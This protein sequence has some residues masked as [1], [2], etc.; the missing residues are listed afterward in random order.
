M[1]ARAPREPI[2]G[3]WL[4]G[5]GALLFLAV[6]VAVARMPAGPA[7]AARSDAAVYRLIAEHRAAEAASLARAA[8]AQARRAHGPGSMQAADA[9]DALVDVA[10]ATGNRRDVPEALT[11]AKESIR[12]REI[13]CGMECPEL[14]KSLL[15]YEA[16]LWRL[17]DYRA[18]LPL[19]ERA[20][21]IR[22]RAFG[23]RSSMV[24]RS[25]YLL[26]EADRAIGDYAAAEKLHRKA[27]SIWETD[28]GPYALDIA[29]SLH[30]LGVLR[31]T[32]GD[33]AGARA[34]IGKALAIREGAAGPE[35]EMVAT[36]INTLGSL[37]VVM[38]D[39]ETAMSLFDRG[40]AI[41]E[42]TLGKND[43]NVARSLANRGRL[44]SAAGDYAAAKTLF[45][46][47]LNIRVS[48]FGP[49]HYLVGRSL[50]DLG[51][52]AVA[53]GRYADA[54]RLFRRA[55]DIQ[56]RDPQARG[57]ELA[58]TLIDDANLALLTGDRARAVRLALEGEAIARDHFL[59]TSRGL[60]EQDALRYETVRSTG[61]DVALSAL[62]PGRSGGAPDPSGPA[63]RVWD[64]IIRSRGMVLDEMAARHRAEPAG[65]TDHPGLAQVA[66]HLP[67]KT[68]L[69]GFVRYGSHGESRGGSTSSYLALVLA[70]GGAA[71]VVVPIGSAKEVEAA[72][73][74][75]QKE[76]GTDPRLDP[77]HEG[78]R[79]YLQTARRLRKVIW[80]PVA[81]K[82]KGL[83]R[84][85]VVPDGA[86]NAVSFAALPG[87]DG[88]YLIESDPSIHYLSAERDITIP[89]RPAGSGFGLLALGG[90]EFDAR[91]APSGGVEATFRSAPPACRRFDA[92]KFGPLP[93][94]R[95]EVDDIESLW[96]AR[97]GALKLTGP[98][99]SEGALKSSAPGR[100]ILHLATHAYFLQNLCPSSLGG[101]L[102]PE[103]G[104]TVG[105][106]P[107]LLSGLALAGANRRSE[108]SGGEE[109]G[110]LTAEEIGALDLSGVEWA[111]L[112]GCETGLGQVLAGEGVVG[113]HRAFKV[114]GVGTLIMSLWPVDDGAA[115]IWMHYLHD[116]RLH[117]LSTVD[118]VR[119]A[120]L[121]MIASQRSS[122]GSTHSYF[123][124]AFVATGDWK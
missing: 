115:R 89:R 1:S 32:M 88:R 80:D 121:R 116:G 29:N 52:L 112:S 107:L 119:R 105:E 100:R 6:G 86:I 109:D 20:L 58:S 103:E 63:A 40:Q 25:L 38:G 94:S 73:R 77:R 101:D 82:L 84:V 97:G 34:L 70:P 10:A 30:Y 68:A 124:G 90:A 4:V 118:A 95:R 71:T 62:P 36:E 37:A 81:P 5:G 106:N 117:G 78:E 72:I 60:S 87:D 59:R 14:A 44:L 28:P 110:I 47:A 54:E 16:L 7:R 64:E 35:S 53:A 56:Q 85:F 79:R 104:A 96:K 12:I 111:V 93:G 113:L 122:G 50:A 102:P 42:R 43:P 21:A 61:L 76:A 27:V 2:V 9:M 65:T 75:W 57:P 123:W 99:A 108:V 45:Q 66:R 92:L 23:P 19:A 91:P 24:A 11:L 69:V 18:A 39:R 13:S 17:E 51:R 31:W 83:R 74:E 3:R 46:R 67:A 33:F 55:L 98:Y 26:A 22:S 41:W 8:L 120:S 48:A 114:A 15:A 49:G